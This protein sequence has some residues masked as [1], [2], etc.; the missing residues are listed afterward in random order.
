MSGAQAAFLARAA[1]FVDYAVAYLLQSPHRS[2]DASARAAAGVRFPAA[3]ACSAI[4]RGQPTARCGCLRCTSCRSAG[5]WCVASSGGRRRVGRG[6]S[7]HRPAGIVTISIT[8][9]CS[10]CTL[11]PQN[12]CSLIVRRR[13]YRQRPTLMVVVDTEEEFD[14]SAPF[15]RQATGVTAMR[16]IDRAQRLCDAR[17]SRAHLRDRLS[18]RDTAARLRG[19]RARWAEEGRC[20]D[21]RASASVGH[22]AVRRGGQ[23]PEQLHVQPAAG[24]AAREDARASCDAIEA[25]TGVAAA[26]VQGRPIRHRPR[27]PRVVRRSWASTSTSASTRAWT[28]RPRADRTSRVSIR[29]RSGSIGRGSCSRCR[30][31]TASS[32]GRARL[33]LWLRDA[34]E[35]LRPLRAPAS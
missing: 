4:S 23:R 22:A 27:R 35:S 8:S 5:A 25:N 7:R 11:R 24:A 33:A 2:P 34:A 3:A 9:T 17:R 15:S 20:A 30:A 18:G 29:G 26:G 14:W 13:R 12:S 6:T 16:H 10:Q 19:P 21:R 28:S 31:R 1:G 32:A